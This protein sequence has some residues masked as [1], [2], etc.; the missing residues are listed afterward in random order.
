MSSVILTVHQVNEY[1]RILLAR[2]PL[3]R[4]VRVRGEISN[5]K[6]H[7]SGH[8]YFSLKDEQ[9]RIQ[10]VL[11]RQKGDGL[12]FLPRDGMQVIA[13]GTVSL[14]G[15]DGQYQL[16][17]YE[18][19]QDGLGDLH[20]AFEKM[21]KM[22]REE[23]LFDAVHKKPL[24]LL[25]Q[26]IAVVTSHTGAAVRDIIRVIKHRNKNID[27]LIIP[28]SVQGRGAARQIARAIDYI[29]T[30]SDIDL[31]I[32]GRG[33]GSIEE[34]WAFNEEIVARAIH[35][36]KI[37]VITAIGHETDF[38][39]ADFVADVRA[40]TPS[41][42]AE[43]AVPEAS[44][45]RSL[46]DGFTKNL[47]DTMTSY[48]K[49]KRHQLDLIKNH[50]VFQTSRMLIDQHSQYLDQL[51]QR[52]SSAMQSIL[53]KN[54]DQLSKAVVTLEAINPLK[55]LSRGYAIATPENGT[56]P[57]RSVKEISPSQRINVLFSDGQ[58]VCYIE[59]IKTMK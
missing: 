3:L 45:M 47:S 8:M 33:G 27:I 59:D 36:S 31:I 38:T 12:S 24:P 28:V 30:R 46:I 6:I 37:P 5:F 40:A 14:Y 29:N 15:R 44:Y 41:N 48:L 4:N 17:V 57:I 7:S 54:Y 42:G 58:T 50:Y 52:F 53:N 2:D 23:G 32:T 1:V 18:M 20:L 22:L 49:T 51:T 16:Y 13:E 56:K 39:I 26:K 21:K 10:C 43:L 19:E 9:D 11:F 25:P 55:V 35:Q 34:L